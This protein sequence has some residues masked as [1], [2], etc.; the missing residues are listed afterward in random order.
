MEEDLLQDKILKFRRLMLV[1]FINVS[2]LLIVGSSKINKKP[3]F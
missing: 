1:R 2:F 3:N